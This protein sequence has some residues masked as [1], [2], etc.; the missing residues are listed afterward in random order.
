MVDQLTPKRWLQTVWRQFK[1]FN[2][3]DGPTTYLWSRW[4]VLRAVGLVY[5]LVF[6]EIIVDWK[7][8]IGPEGIAPLTGILDAFRQQFPEGLLA[9]FRAPSLFWLSASPGMVAVLAWGGLAAAVAVLLNFWPRLMLF[10]CWLFFLSFVALENFFAQTQPDQLMLEVALLCV[11]LAPAGIRPGLA[12]QAAPRR[13]AVWALRWMLIRLMFEAGL[14]KFYYGG[15]MWRDFTAMDVMYETAPFPTIFGYWF[16]QLPHAFH[17]LEVALTFAAEI[18]APLLAVLG[19]RWGRWFAFWSWLVLQAGIQVTCNFGWLNVAAIALGV[20]LIDDQM[21]TGALKRIRLQRLA[22]YV[23]GRVK[24]VTAPVIG[25]KALW[26]LRVALAAQ[27]V[28]ALYFYA[29]APTRIPPEDVPPA[30]HTPMTVL[31]AG[32]RSANSYALFGNLPKIRYD[33]EFLGSNDDGET[34]R[35]YPFRYK[36]QRPDRVSPFIA[37][38]YPRFEAIL[39]NQKVTSTEGPLYLAVAERLLRRDPAVMA[40]FEDDPFPDRPAQMIRTPNYR[41]AMTDIKTRQ[42]TGQYWRKEYVGD[43]TASVYV[44][45][46]GE[47]I[48]AD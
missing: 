6:A 5:I 29:I 23:A 1:E 4:L 44:N 14:A 45:A 46:Q 17:V 2:A 12:A 7:A 39:Q 37:P 31:F 48:V 25:R 13:I 35:S 15:A 11:V 20:I 10:I 43:Y 16:H 26:G 21:L 30:I 38:W 40:L 36:I 24:A 3:V 18:I 28:I 9:Y 32:L 41:F 22:D 34:W 42:A 27:F 33:V 8:L 19:G 47:I